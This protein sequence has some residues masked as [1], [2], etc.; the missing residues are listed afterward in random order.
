MEELINTYMD[1]KSF[2]DNLAPKEYR[3]LKIQY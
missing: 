3:D 1:H 2:L